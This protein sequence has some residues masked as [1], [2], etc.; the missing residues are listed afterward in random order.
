MI[1]DPEFQG[2]GVGSKI[3]KDLLGKSPLKPIELQTTLAGEFY[4]KFGFRYLPAGS[5][6]MYLSVGRLK[7]ISKCISLKIDTI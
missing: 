2:K 4:K 1:V 6:K 7:S 5:D 3:L